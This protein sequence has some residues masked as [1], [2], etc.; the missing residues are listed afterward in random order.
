MS[1][2]VVEYSSKTATIWRH[3]DQHPNYLCDPAR[4]MDPTSFGCYV[5]AMRGEHI[6]LTSI[7]GTSR[8][9]NRIY[10]R[11]TG[12]WPANYPLSYFS[13]FDRLMVVHEV[14]NSQSLTAFIR[15]L[16]QLKPS[17]KIIGVPTQPYGLLRQRWEN[18]P[19]V[20]SD[21]RD[22]INA[23]DVFITIVASTLPAWQVFST[24]P[25]QYLPQ[26]YPVEHAIQFFQSAADK[27]PI[28]FIAGVPDRPAIT[29]GFKVAAALQRQFPDYVIHLTAA[30]D[31]ELDIFHLQDAKYA[32]QPFMPWQEHLQ[33]LATVKIVINTDFTQ[34]R[35]RVQMD[36]AAVGTPAVGADSD[37]QLDLFPRQAADINTPLSSIIQTAAGLLSNP[38]TYRS[39]V[40]LAKNKLPFYNYPSS[41]ARLDRLFS[42]IDK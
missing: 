3:S 25:V 32:I 26:P 38:D 41:A 17:L 35:G 18:D 6:P 23:C 16:S 39:T 42:T 1:F 13:P 14:A 21:L 24:R 40:E 33:Y 31:A 27:K 5:S 4:E 30:A 20:K 22:F 12:H 9:S 8:L 15:R 2:A 37:A 19:L 29:H 10:R 11:C 28:I 7:L 34:T 36:C